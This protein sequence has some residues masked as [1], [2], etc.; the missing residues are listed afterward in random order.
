ML[1]A[2]LFKI[3]QSAGFRIVNDSFLDIPNVTSIQGK[4]EW[5]Q[6]YFYKIMK[7]DRVRNKAYR[8]VINSKV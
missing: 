5:Y 4:M 3:L 8:Q 7:N 6:T 1:I 2:Y